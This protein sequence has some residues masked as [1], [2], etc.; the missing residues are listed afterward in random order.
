MHVAG[1]TSHAH[2]AANIPNYY[3]QAINSPK[4]RFWQKCIY[5]ELASHQKN[6]TWTLLPTSGAG[7]VLTSRRVFITKQPP[8]ENGKLCEAAKARLVA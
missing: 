2:V 1:I 3:K 8:D 7:N 5:K 4:E 6:R